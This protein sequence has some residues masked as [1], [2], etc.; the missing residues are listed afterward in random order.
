MLE[1]YG[2]FYIV[3]NLIFTISMYF[4]LSSYYRFLFIFF[5]IF[6]K[7]SQYVIYGTNQLYLYSLHSDIQIIKLCDT[8]LAMSLQM[9]NILK[10]FCYYLDTFYESMYK[11]YLDFYHFMKKNNKIKLYLEHIEDEIE[12][13]NIIYINKREQYVQRMFQVAMSNV[14]EIIKENK[15]NENSKN[16]S[17][18]KNDKKINKYQK[19]IKGTIDKIKNKKKIS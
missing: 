5:V 9:M 15:L 18:K 7:H 12:Q 3:F 13:Y 6:R 4:Y 19:N 17:K 16:Q 2:L 1:I 11:I 10:T 8:P 14:I